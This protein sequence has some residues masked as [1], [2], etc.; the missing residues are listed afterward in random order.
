MISTRTCIYCNKNFL[1]I[2]G[3]VFAN[4]VRWCPENKTNGDKGSAK[5]SQKLK[6]FHEHRLGKL[7]EFK[8]NCQRCNASFFV[9]EKEKKFPQ[10]SNYYCSVSCSKSRGQR[11]EEEKQAIREK[12]SLPRIS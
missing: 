12:L 7:K 10:K 6:E 2:E 1:D 11:T 8:V 4:H 3:K 5:T 9:N